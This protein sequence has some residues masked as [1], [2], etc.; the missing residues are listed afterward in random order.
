MAGTRLFPYFSL[1]G[2]IMVMNLLDGRRD[3]C[4]PP[5]SDDVHSIS[6]SDQSERFHTWTLWDFF[7]F[8]FCYIGNHLNG[9]VR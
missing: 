6:L 3:G 4:S 2:I 9:G 8:F 7:G 1:P 5:P